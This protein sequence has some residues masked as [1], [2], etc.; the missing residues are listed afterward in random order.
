[1]EDPGTLLSRNT[2]WQVA[3]KKKICALIVSIT[4][5]S[6]C[7]AA[8]VVVDCCAGVEAVAGS[9]AQEKAA[10]EFCKLACL[11]ISSF[12]HLFGLQRGRTI[13]IHVCSDMRDFYK[14]CKRPWFVGAALVDD[15][16]VTQ[17]VRSL[18]KIEN[19]EALVT[20]E[21][22][23]WIVRRAAGRGCPRWLD[24]GLAQW[25]AGQK[26]GLSAAHACSLPRNG[27]DLRRLD[28]KL[29]ARDLGR[30]D[31]KR[32]YL[33]SLLLVDR[34]ISAV[35]FIK[36]VAALPQLKTVSDPWQVRIVGKSLGKLIFEGI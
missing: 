35:G 14:R 30:K 4:A 19:H 33:T 5:V 13:T 25:L 3:L 34:L 32:A 31:L 2:A 23:H 22:V 9:P 12:E 21:L 7:R 18:R 10:H 1:M 28:G 36:L 8:P 15:E 29:G 26:S 6:V 27:E 24:E 20:H 11:K 17:P 16:I